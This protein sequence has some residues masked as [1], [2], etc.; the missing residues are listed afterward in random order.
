MIGLLPV[1]GISTP[2]PREGSM[3][4]AVPLRVSSPPTVYRG[5]AVLVTLS[6]VLGAGNASLRRFDPFWGV[7][8]AGTSVSASDP[9][10]SVAGW[11]GTRFDEVTWARQYFGKTST[12]HRHNFTRRLGSTGSVASLFMDVV[13]AADVKVFSTY[14][15]E[16]CYRFHGF[17]IVRSE[18]VDV[19]AAAEAQ[20][21]TY[22][23]KAT[24]KGWAVVAWVSPVRGQGAD[25]RFE[26]VV[27]LASVDAR[28][29]AA[30]AG[31]SATGE[32]VAFARSLVAEADKA[33][34]RR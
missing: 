15:L 17:D 4:A 7:R 23:D 27:L 25:K 22:L 9:S 19:G 13:N 30:E 34:S 28:R 31:E 24:R 10:L 3:G 1:F 20:A 26:R 14:G 33:G 2:P 6:A 8:A 5:L 11:S 18:R 32:L 29:D 16:D 21:I 12:W